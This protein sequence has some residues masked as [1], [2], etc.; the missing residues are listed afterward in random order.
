MASKRKRLNLKEKIDVLEVVEK[1]KLSVRSLAERS[2][3]GITQISELLKDKEGIRKMWVLNS[4]E[5]L[6]FRNTETSEIDEVLMKWFRSA[7]AKNIP[8][9]GVLFQEKSRELGESLGL[10]TFKTSN[11]WLE[12]FRTRHNISFK[13]ICG[14]EKSVNPNEV[15]DWIGRLKSLLKG[16]D[17]KDV[18][19][20][21]ETGV[22]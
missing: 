18:F 8:V 1:E 16:Y 19:S 9:N 11:G 17:D 6:K 13:Q 14:E 4:N 12:K 22:F 20:A 5:N 2:H 10:G 21:D 7:R 3:V 15:T